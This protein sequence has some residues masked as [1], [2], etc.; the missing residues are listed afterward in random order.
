MKNKKKVILIGSV[1][2]VLT[3]AIALGAV[4]IPKIRIG[5]SEKEA[6]AKQS[7]DPVVAEVPVIP[8]PEFET[9][10]E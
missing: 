2:A 4:L 7:D 9:L 10:A 8:E 5:R 6:E 3:V 1:A